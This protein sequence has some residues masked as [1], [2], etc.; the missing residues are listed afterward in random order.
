[1]KA[2]TRMQNHS[3][4]QAVTRNFVWKDTLRSIK[5]ITKTNHTVAKNATK[6]STQKA[7]LKNHEK[8]HKAE[9]PFSCQARDKTKKHLRIG[10]LNICKGLNNKEAQLLNMIEEEE[11]DIIGVSETDLKDF[12]ESLPYTLRGFKTFWPLKRSETNM[13]RKFCCV[14]HIESSTLVQEKKK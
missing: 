11:I 12:D 13:G 8:I 7:S 14:L 5:E 2:F 9:E 4:A 1:M 6:S 3:I 10:N